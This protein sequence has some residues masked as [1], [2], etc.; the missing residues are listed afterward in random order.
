VNGEPLNWDW[1]YPYTE[2]PLITDIV[3]YEETQKDKAGKCRYTLREQLTFI[4]P[5]ASLKPTK[6][7]VKFPDEIYSETRNPWMKKYEW[8]TKPRISLPW[9]PK[10]DLT[11]VEAL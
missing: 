4:L 3:K 9:N 11:S 8:E 1:V 5:E 2:C 6:R 7:R 10:Y